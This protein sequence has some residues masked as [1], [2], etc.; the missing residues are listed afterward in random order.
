MTHRP[1]FAHAEFAAKKKVTRREKFL[2]RMEAVIPWSQLLAVI[3]PFYP[4]GKRGRPPLG[5]ERMLRVYF[6]QQ[7]HALADGRSKTRS[8]TATPSTVLRG[9]N[10]PPK[11][12]PMPPPG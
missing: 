9:L 10:S 3:E 8:T 5:L 6:L 4:Q 1:S 12:C 7:W 11:A 2:A